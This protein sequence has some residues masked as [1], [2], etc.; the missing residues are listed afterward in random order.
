METG[1]MTPK[2]PFI[3]AI[4]ARK[5]GVGKTSLSLALAL[6]FVAKG[7]RVLFVDVDVDQADGYWTL[8]GAE[9]DSGCVRD[10]HGMD[11]LWVVDPSELLSLDQ[12]DVVIID[13]RPSVVI[14]AFVA[15]IAHMV[16][17]PTEGGT[18]G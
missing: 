3:L 2:R 15:S 6:H 16:I 5:G 1:Q 8:I 4:S 10:A 7:R 13:G 14:G 9:P 17:I 18:R 11:V 12:Y